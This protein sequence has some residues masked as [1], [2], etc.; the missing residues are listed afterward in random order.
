[1]A[2]QRCVLVVV[3]RCDAMNTLKKYTLKIRTF[4]RGKAKLKIRYLLGGPTLVVILCVLKYI[5]TT[6]FTTAGHF[7]KAL[8]KGHTTTWIWNLHSDAHD[9]D[10][11]SLTLTT[12]VFASNLAHLSNVFFWISGMH[13]HGCYNSNYL[14][15]LKDPAIDMPS[16][17]LAVSSGFGLCFSIN[18]DSG[19]YF[20]GIH[21]TSGIFQLW[22]SL[23]IISGVHLKYACTPSLIGFVICMMVSYLSMA[24]SVLICF[25]YL[26]QWQVC[27]SLSIHHLT[28]LF[29]LSSISYC[30]HLFHISLPVNSLLDSGIDLC[31]LVF[32]KTN[33]ISAYHVGFPFGSE[34]MICFQ[35]NS[36]PTSFHTSIVF[37]HH[38]A[39]SLCLNISA[40]LVLRTCY[41][42]G[43]YIKVLGFPY[44]FINWH[45][46]LSLNLATIPSCSITLAHHITAIPMY[47]LMAS[48]Y[49]TL[50]CLFSHHTYIGGLLIIGA[51]AHT[52]LGL[53]RTSFAKQT[54]FHTVISMRDVIIG[55]LIHATFFIGFHSFP[56]YIHND[57]FQGFGRPEDIFSDNTIQLKPALTLSMTPS[58]YN[59]DIKMLDK[60]MLPNTHQ[61]LGTAD[62]IVHHI[63]AFTIH[64]TLLI[65]L[66]GT[67][68]ARNS[69]LV[70]DKLELGF[71]YPCDGPGRGGTCQISPFDHI[72]L[73]VFWM[74]NSLSVIIFHYLYKMQSDVWGIYN[75][76]LN[77]LSNIPSGSFSVNSS[78]ING[79]LRNLLWSSSAQV[80]QSYG[81]SIATY[82][83]IFITSHFIWAF[84][85]MFIFSGRGYWQELIESILWAHHKLKI[86]PHIQ[87]RALSISQGRAVG[88][89]HYILG[90]VGC[91]WAFFIS[92]ML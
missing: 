75:I 41:P 10:I 81:T 31:E 43:Y 12:K 82:G 23:G 44:L 74:Y 40:M 21:I 71:R 76:E 49:S 30:G 2:V 53:I 62:F 66:K 84:S 61:E 38:L 64:T 25:M 15:W 88:F 70:S 59:L 68:F 69:R 63:H 46:Q 29:G 6:Q 54:F 32:P 55:H 80:I 58:L 35:L 3:M 20:Q 11:Q 86:I 83:L 85:L 4:I 91:T 18:S 57:T 36:S 7:N 28:I 39:I 8:S 78:T 87:P 37:A 1:M 24:Q 65:L 79:W 56:L 42:S 34:L 16:A 33:I 26:F 72:Y 9:F 17:H 90:G 77:S 45:F 73:A 48:D 52:S 60:I 89:I 92:R 47:P 50:L 51:G 19:N 5:N 22:R 27:S 67:L 14:V 13:F